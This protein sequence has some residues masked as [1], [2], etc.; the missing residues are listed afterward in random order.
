MLAADI[1]STSLR[2]KN[3]ASE[4][5]PVHKT[6]ILFQGFAHSPHFIWIQVLKGVLSLLFQLEFSWGLF[7]I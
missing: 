3:K 6:N 7:C 5:H 4:G 2:Y 1:K